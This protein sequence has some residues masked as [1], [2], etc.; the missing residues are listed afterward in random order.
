MA[1]ERQIAA[2]RRNARSSTDPRSRDGKKRASKN[3]YRHGLAAGFVTGQKHAKRVEKPARNIAGKTAD[4]VTLEHARSAAEAEFWL[5]RVREVKP[6]LIERVFAFGSIEAPTPFNS[7]GEVIRFLN[8]LGR[9]T[10]DVPEPIEDA[11][12]MPSTEPERLAEAVRRTLPELLK[13]DRYEQRAA[14]LRE[15]SLR[16]IYESKRA[17]T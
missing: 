8:A 14:R 2:N 7:V 10:A 9:G 13:L 15:Q 4:V 11:A 1:T 5:A 16:A 6:A 17:L 12:T 3:S